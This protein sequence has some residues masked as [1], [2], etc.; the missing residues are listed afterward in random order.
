MPEGVW[1]DVLSDAGHA[2]IFFDDAFDRARGEAAVIAGSVDGASVFTIVQ[3]EGWKGI[4]AGAKVFGDAVG[5]GFGNEDWTVLAAFTT[6]DELAALEINR[7]TVEIDKFGNAEAARI[8]KLDDGA[9]P[10]TGFRR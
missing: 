7:I 2:G 9:V 1:A 4:A 3:E 10:E 5:G 8:E 6:D